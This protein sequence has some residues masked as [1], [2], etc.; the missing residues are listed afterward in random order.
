MR[1]TVAGFE[2]R[3]GVRYD[4][5]ESARKLGNP[6]PADGDCPSLFRFP[7]ACGLLD[8]FGGEAKTLATGEEMWAAA[9][10]RNREAPGAEHFG[11]IAILQPLVFG[12]VETKD[13]GIWVGANRA[14]PEGTTVWVPP[15]K[16]AARLPWDSLATAADVTP[17][18]GAVERERALV[19]DAL[20]RYLDELQRIDAAGIGPKEER[21]CDRPREERLKLLAS[22]GISPSWT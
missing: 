21:W 6:L 13:A 19:I 10:P 9:D 11:T 15:S 16:L 5:P 1:E 8:A 17:L 7:G 3:T 12:M 2:K 22:A 18:L 20:E 14:V 4:P